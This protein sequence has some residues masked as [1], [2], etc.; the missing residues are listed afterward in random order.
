MAKDAKAFVQACPHCQWYKPTVQ[1][2][3]PH[4]PKLVPQRPFSEISLDWVAYITGQPL[5]GGSLLLEH[6][7]LNMQFAYCYSEQEV[8]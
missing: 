6:S 1:R 4:I 2:V 8:H 3:P 5:A 7:F